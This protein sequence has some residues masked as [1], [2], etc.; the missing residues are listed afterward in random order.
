MMQTQ[1]IHWHE[2]MFLRPQHFQ[3]STRHSQS[4][5]DRGDRWNCHYNWG[6]RSFALDQQ[7]LAN[8]RFS[9]R[10]LE[11]R[12]RDGT[13]V[14]MPDDLMLDALDVKPAL[15]RNGQTTVYLALPLVQASRSNVAESQEDHRA[16]YTL[17]TQNLQ[18]E[19]TGLNH[20]QITIRR[21]NIKLL[22]SDQ[23]RT[24]YEVLPLARLK[25]ADRAEAAPE[26]DTSFVPPLLACEAWQPLQVEILNQVYDRIGKKLEF[27]SAQIASRNINFDSQNQG[28]RLLFEQLR[29]MNEAYLPMGVRIFAQG[30][31]PLEAYL[32]LCELAGKLAIYNPGRT[33]P[34]LPR[35]DHDD[36]ATCF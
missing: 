32:S 24:G 34:A 16:R 30:I 6:L 31:H 12:F 27:L 17:E 9:V 11:A 23:D 8:Y 10:S 20:H 18:D 1:P 15:L 28:D 35:Y 7:A 14:A 4:Q 21:L 29:T 2:G 3:L 13:Q 22:T 33:L 5:A 19:N 25:K 36:L 26:L